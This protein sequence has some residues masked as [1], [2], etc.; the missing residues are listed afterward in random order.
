MNR[1]IFIKY[2]DVFNFKTQWMSLM[3]LSMATCVCFCRIER[4]GCYHS[5]KWYLLNKR[6]TNAYATRVIKKEELQTIIIKTLF[7]V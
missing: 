2:A 5:L 3:S 6:K 4:N 7:F 1:F